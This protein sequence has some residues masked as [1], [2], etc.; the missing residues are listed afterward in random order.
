MAVSRKV[1]FGEDAVG[2]RM[3]SRFWQVGLVRL[4]SAAGVVSL[5]L[6]N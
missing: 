4:L 1:S 5:V 2:P 6:V 3:M